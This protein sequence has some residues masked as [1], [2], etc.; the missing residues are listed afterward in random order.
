[1]VHKKVRKVVEVEVV[2]PPRV[3]RMET[4]DPVRLEW[5]V[6]HKRVARRMEEELQSQS[7]SNQTLD[8]SRKANPKMSLS[9]TM[10]EPVPNDDISSSYYYCE[11]E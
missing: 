4:E 2:V 8:R 9:V 3:R 10:N 7:N 1:L 5:V 11:G 6:V